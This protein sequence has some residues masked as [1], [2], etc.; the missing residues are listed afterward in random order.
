VTPRGLFITFEGI[1]GCGKTTQLI[2][3]EKHL[4]SKNIRPLVTREPGGNRLSE[5]IRSLVLDPGN[6]D[7]G[8]K[9]ELLLYLASRAQHVSEA[10]L[11]ALKKGRTVLCDRF[12]DATIAYQAGGR[13]LD[14][15][16]VIA[17]DRFA[18]DSLRPDLTFLFDLPVREAFARLKRSGKKSDR[19][20]KGGAAFMG[21]VRKAYLALAKKEPRRIAVINAARSVDEIHAKIKRI[22]E[23]FV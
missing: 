11:P 10:I 6:R 2:L 8:K 14:A 7:M 16:A 12:S 20:E 18:T 3:L 17:L 23:E 13:A 15:G 4:R 1:D 21:R 22:L 5:K 9:T 19:L